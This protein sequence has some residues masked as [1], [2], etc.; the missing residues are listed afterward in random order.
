M[1]TLL[2]ITPAVAQ[3][4][5]NP[6]D[7]HN[8]EAYQIKLQK[9]LETLTPQERIIFVMSQ[10]KSSSNSSKECELDW[11]TKNKLDKIED[12]YDKLEEMDRK[13]RYG[14]YSLDCNCNCDC[15]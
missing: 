6:I 14:S 10:S 12:I 2:N 4:T 7:F 15:Y 8:F 5:T 11:N 1:Y 9:F 3:E 13:L